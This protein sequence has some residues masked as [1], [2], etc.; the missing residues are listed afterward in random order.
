MVDVNSLGAS[1]KG[2]MIELY[3]RKR[4]YDNDLH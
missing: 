3:T 2:R 1:Q 4:S